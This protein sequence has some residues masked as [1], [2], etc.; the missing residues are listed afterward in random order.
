ML[1]QQDTMPATHVG[2]LGF[3]LPLVPV[4][5]PTVRDPGSRG[6]GSSIWVLAIHGAEWGLDVFLAP[7]FGQA[8]FSPSS[9]PTT[10]LH[11]TIFFFKQLVERW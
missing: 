9:Q 2:G 6:D 3:R 11:L 5:L 7:G 4:W 10:P 1:E 8:V